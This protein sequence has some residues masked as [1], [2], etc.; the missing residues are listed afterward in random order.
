MIVAKDKN[1]S[2][3]FRFEG[4]RYQFINGVIES[5]CEKLRDHVSKFVTLEETVS[6]PKEEVA[7]TKTSK[8]KS[9]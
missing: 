2:T 6:T 1:T 3:I 7:V 8:K 9:K 5:N 4:K